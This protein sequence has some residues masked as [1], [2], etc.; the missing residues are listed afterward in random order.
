MKILDIS[1]LD[2]FEQGNTDVKMKLFE[3]VIGMLHNLHSKGVYHGDCHMDN[4]MGIMNKQ[5]EWVIKEKIFLPKGKVRKLQKK[6]D[7]DSYIKTG[8]E[9]KFIDFGEGGFLKG[10]KKTIL[11][12]MKFDYIKLYS[13]IHHTLDNQSD[14]H[15]T[16][17]FSNRIK[18]ILKRI[19]YNIEL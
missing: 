6:N 16:E 2:I 13:S 19:E 1:L 8:F 7:L 14:S 15:L 4:I 10:N 17:I 5:N 18:N 9:W 3:Q 12:K 11:N